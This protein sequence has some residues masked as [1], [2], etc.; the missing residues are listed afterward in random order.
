MQSL[1]AKPY[2][3]KPGDTFSSIA[4]QFGFSY[5]ADIYNNPANASFRARRPNPN[6]LRPGDQV[7]IPPTPQ[8]ARQVLQSRLD[9]LTRLRQQTDSMYQ[10]IESEMN[11]N[12]RRYDAVANGVDAVAT[13]A[14]LFA[15]LVSL[16]AKGFAAL[17]LSGPAL[18]EA[19]KELAKQGLKL[20][21]DPLQDPA[22][23]VAA[24]QL[25]AHD[26][27]VWA[28]GK[29]GIE[30]FLNI[31]SPSWWAGV[32]GNLQDGKSWSQAVA[33]SPEDQ[34][35]VAK[36]RV[37]AQRQQILQQIDARINDTRALLNGVAT[38]GLTSLYEKGMRTYA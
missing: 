4:K 17:K 9:D 30:S 20:A 11:A 1:N 29:I 12:L 34:L 38:T 16:T 32:V 7:M 23:K 8:Q 10:Q 26:G 18:D 2:V 27:L 3:V 36:Q 33:T 15:G 28:V 31:Q 35:R 24:N 25:G 21:T 19:N 22:L 37:E 13:V 5:W 14:E 6:Q